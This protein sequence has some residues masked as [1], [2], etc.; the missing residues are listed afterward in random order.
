M[1]LD[2]ENL[3]A[4]VVNPRRIR[5]FA[6]AKNRLAKTDKIDAEIIALFAKEIKP[7]QRQFKDEALQKLEALVIRR[8]QIVNMIK[9]ENNRLSGCHK[10]VKNDI[11]KTVRTLEKHLRKIEKDIHDILK[12]DDGIKHKA[13]L[14][15][16]VPGIGD[17]MTSVLISLM[18]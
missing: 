1:S 8:D 16:S 14:L 5:D 6:R 4:I 15:S 18:P 7:E 10:S 2:K 11:I 3:A 9:A 13:E 17:V 12:K